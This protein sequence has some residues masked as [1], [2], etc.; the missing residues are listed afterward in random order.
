[1]TEQPADIGDVK[2]QDNI[3]YLRI[4][5]DNKRIIFKTQKTNLKW[6]LPTD[7]WCHKICTKLYLESRNW[8]IKNEDKNHERK[9][10]ISG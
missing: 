9:T 6:C 1:M 8:S 5:V 4:E 10:T 7:P 2:V 3:N